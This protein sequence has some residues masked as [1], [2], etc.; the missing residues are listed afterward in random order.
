[1]PGIGLCERC[2]GSSRRRR[3]KTYPTVSSTKPCGSAGFSSSRGSMAA[4][5][6]AAA[7]I[8]AD[9]ADVMVFTKDLLGSAVR[10]MLRLRQA[11]DKTIQVISQR[12]L[13]C[14]ARVAP[15]LDHKIEHI[16]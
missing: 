8:A 13:T 5:A 11:D 10:S 14:E 16:F 2:T 4:R 12:D 15:R 3:S 1:M 7:P 9:S 6:R